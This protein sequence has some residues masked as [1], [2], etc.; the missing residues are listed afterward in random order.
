MKTKGSLLV[1][2]HYNPLVFCPA[3]QPV[4]DMTL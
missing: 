3:D 4:T 1:F 2:V